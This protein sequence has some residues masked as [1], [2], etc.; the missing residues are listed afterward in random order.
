MSPS[1]FV[2]GRIDVVRP[3]I[4]FLFQPAVGQGIRI[5]RCGGG[6]CRDE[7]DVQLFRLRHQNCPVNAELVFLALALALPL[8]LALALALG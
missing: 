5:G 2:G 7:A 4:V 1:G 6:I 8:P 3:A